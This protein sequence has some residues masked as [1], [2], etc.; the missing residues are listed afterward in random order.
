MRNYVAGSSTCLLQQCFDLGH[1]MHKDLS[2][3]SACSF[4]DFA[5]GEKFCS[6]EWK[7]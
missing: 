2:R 7:Y 6:I 3:L 5:S 1:F 4:H